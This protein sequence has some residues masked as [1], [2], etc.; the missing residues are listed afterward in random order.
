MRDRIEELAERLEPLFA[1]VAEE[2]RPY[3]TQV[4]AKYGLLTI[5]A[6]GGLTPAMRAAVVEAE[7]AAKAVCEGC[8]GST[9]C[10]KCRSRSRWPGR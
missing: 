1:A 3:L 6:D 5:Y 4:K 8:G 10:S 9:P 2:D 7:E